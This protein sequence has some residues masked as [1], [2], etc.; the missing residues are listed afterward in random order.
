[1][2]IAARLKTTLFG[3]IMTV[4]AALVPHGAEAVNIKEV[5]SAGG[6]TAWLTD[7]VRSVF[8]Q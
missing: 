4:A 6:I 2:P 3:A 5:T 8:P 1:M 7:A